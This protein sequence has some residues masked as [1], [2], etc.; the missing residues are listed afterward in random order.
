MQIT[1]QESCSQGY[2]AHNG[3]RCVECPP[4]GTSCI[5]GGFATRDDF[6]L[7]GSERGNVTLGDDLRTMRCRTDGLCSTVVYQEH[8]V[9]R[10]V[11]AGHTHGLLCGVCDAGYG[12]SVG[13]KSLNPDFESA[14]ISVLRIGLNFVMAT[15]FLAQVQLDWGSI[16]RRTFDIAKATSGGVPPLV[17]CLGVTFADEMA[18]SLALPLMLLVVVPALPAFILVRLRKAGTDPGRDAFNKDHLYFLYGG[19]RKGFEYWEAAVLLRKFLL[20]VAMVFLADDNHGLQVTAAMWI[21]CVATVMQLYNKPYQNRTE[22]TLETYS[23]CGTTVVL[24]LGQLILLADGANGLGAS[25]YVACQV[26]VM[27]V[28]LGVMAQFPIDAD[29]GRVK[30]EAKASKL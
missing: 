13:K 14:T 8:L 30:H 2:F 10:T 20:L 6:F 16:V 18:F 9:A 11:C 27:A 7:I 19:Y 3:T 1:V 26:G 28:V 24:M 23:L 25:G 12:M 15:G 21:M 29:G 4:K 22:E 5:D 17:A